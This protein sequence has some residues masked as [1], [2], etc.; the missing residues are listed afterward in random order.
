[1]FC[2]HYPTW[3]IK[4]NIKMDPV[5]R[6]ALG[7]ALPKRGKANRIKRTDAL[8]KRQRKSFSQPHVKR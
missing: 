1:M 8:L 2:I 7:R 4:R 5:R 3:I 6:K